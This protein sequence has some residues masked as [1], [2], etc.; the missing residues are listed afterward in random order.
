M[1]LWEREHT[2]FDQPPKLILSSPTRNF[3]RS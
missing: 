1:F 2:K 3:S